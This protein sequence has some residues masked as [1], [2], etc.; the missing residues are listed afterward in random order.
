MLWAPAQKLFRLFSCV[1]E[2]HT[3]A[4]QPDRETEGIVVRAVVALEAEVLSVRN[5]ALAV[6]I[7]TAPEMRGPTRMVPIS[8]SFRSHALCRG[9]SPGI[10]RGMHFALL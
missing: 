3:A 6:Q 7:G 1:L 10:I 2:N 5:A 8:P 4:G 9:N